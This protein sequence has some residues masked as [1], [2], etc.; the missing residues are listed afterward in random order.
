MR[1]ETG[2]EIK[3]PG[4]GCDTQTMV[5]VAFHWTLMISENLQ[6]CFFYRRVSVSRINEV[7]F[8]VT[9]ELGSISTMLVTPS[10]EP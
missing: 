4:N 9:A 6:T 1:R 7:S 5:V 10:T 3:P 8:K 2:R